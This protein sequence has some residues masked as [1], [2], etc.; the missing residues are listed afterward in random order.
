MA[1]SPNRPILAIPPTTDYNQEDFWGLATR[2]GVV[3]MREPLSERL[4]DRVRRIYVLASQEARRFNHEYIGPEHILLGLLREGT[5]IAATVLRNLN[6][7]LSE[8]RQEVESLLQSGPT[9]T[10]AGKLP[11]TRTAREVVEYS[12]EEARN[13]SHGFIGSEHILLGLIRARDGLAA[14]LLTNFGLTLERVRS[15]IAR[16]LQPPGAAEREFL[17]AVYRRAV[18]FCQPKIEKRTGVALGRIEV[19][20]C[21]EFHQHVADELE[22]RYWLP[23][24]MFRRL[25]LR[26]RVREV[27]QRLAA[28]YAESARNCSAVYYGGA[29][30]VS[31]MGGTAHEDAMAIVVMHELSH[32]LWERLEGKPL[33]WGL[34][35]RKGNAADRERFD[36]LS[37][38]SASYAERIWFVD[39]YPPSA[40][41]VLARWKL[42]PD[43]PRSKG[44][45]RVQ[46]LVEEHGPGI[47][48]E[49]PKRWRSL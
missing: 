3:P 37:E 28:T 39:L 5:G 18:D 45:H 35:A 46:Q 31:F 42:Q 24:R 22:R 49:I 16:L 25:F 15:E 7:D 32:A 9:I 12:V 2:S 27:S 40:R 43:S 38:G 26:Q 41:D 8:V 30:Y 23:I 10:S 1:T 6:L 19:R 17:L 34:R 47:L 44:L 4:T 48:L 14:Q 20:D 36:L 13:L 11:E 33:V 21:A 29:I